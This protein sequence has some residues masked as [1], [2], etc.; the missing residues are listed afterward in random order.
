MNDYER[1]RR[2]SE[3]LKNEYPNGTRVQLINMEDEKAVPSGT[4]GT[5]MAVDSMATN[6]K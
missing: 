3:S 4:R 1:L 6:G 2:I 5:V